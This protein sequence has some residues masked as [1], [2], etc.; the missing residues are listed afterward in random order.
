MQ[1]S[2]AAEFGLLTADEVE[3]AGG[4]SADGAAAWEQA[5]RIF[6]VPVGGDKYPGFQF[7]HAGHPIPVIARVID[8]LGEKLT[9]PWSIALW[10][11]GSNT[12]LGGV[13]PV[14]VLET[15]AAAVH[16]AARGLA[17]EIT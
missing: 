12:W 9:G 6:S 17:A 16:L 4:L 10:F 3:T 2:L 15:D 13:R 7:D 5:Q 8:E 14:D 11:V 1:A